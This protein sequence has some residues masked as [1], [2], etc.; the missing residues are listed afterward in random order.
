MRN[1]QLGK[2]LESWRARRIL[3]TCAWRSRELERA[4]R[5]D[6]LASSGARH[7]KNAYLFAASLLPKKDK[8]TP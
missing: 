5:G 1:Q 8:V 4:N 2:A 3:I 6:F 7:H